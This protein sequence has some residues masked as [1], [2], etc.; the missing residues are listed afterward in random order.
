MLVMVTFDPSMHIDRMHMESDACY[1]VVEHR[2]CK[3]SM[4]RKWKLQMNKRRHEA[5][6]RMGEVEVGK[7]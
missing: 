2:A 1:R 5:P 6:F 4:Y 7:C 3:T